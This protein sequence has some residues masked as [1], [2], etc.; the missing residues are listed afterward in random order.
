MPGPI[1]ALRA[2]LMP[3][4]V[5]KESPYPE[6]WD[7]VLDGL[8][9]RSIDNWDHWPLPQPAGRTSPT[10]ERA[11]GALNRR[12]PGIF[13]GVNVRD[14]PLWSTMAGSSISAETLLGGRDI[15]MNPTMGWV[16]SQA[17]LERTLIHELQ[18][19][20]QNRSMQLHDQE[21]EFQ[22]PYEKRPAEIDAFAAEDRYWK[23]IVEPLVQSWRSWD[24]PDQKPIGTWRN[25]VG[26]PPYDEPF[27][28]YGTL[29]SIFN[30]N[31]APPEQHT[32]KSKKERP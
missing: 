28:T 6:D 31:N 4:T 16:E 30:V 1:D 17:E 29:S 21:R 32:R 5:K 27:G 9:D 26:S 22:L 23:G 10:V 12:T 8:M 3:K 11:M 13:R 18:H 14:A 19:I 15:T 25:R 7:S 24:K 2:L 20:Q